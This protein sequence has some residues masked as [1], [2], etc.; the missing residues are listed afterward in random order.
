MQGLELVVDLLF[1][2]G[3]L[4]PVPLGSGAGGVLLFQAADLVLEVAFEAAHHGDLL[5]AEFRQVG[6]EQQGALLLAPPLGHQHLRLR[7]ITSTTLV[8][9]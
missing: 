7:M 1:E 3:D 8:S 6:V 9:G 5:L 2:A 4:L